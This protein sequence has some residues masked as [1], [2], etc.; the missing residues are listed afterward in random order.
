MKKYS[1]VSVCGKQFPHPPRAWTCERLCEPD[2]SSIDHIRCCDVTKSWNR[3][4]VS[5]FGPIARQHA[6]FSGPADDCCS[7]RENMNSNARTLIDSHTTW[8]LFQFSCLIQGVEIALNPPEQ[9]LSFRR[10]YSPG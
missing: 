10:K 3:D 8:E 2:T 4:T 5:Y 1:Y 9:I 6:Y 7:D